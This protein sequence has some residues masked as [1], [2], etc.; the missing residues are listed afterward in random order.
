MHSGPIPWGT[1]SILPSRWGAGRG[2]DWES[3]H[4][5]VVRPLGTPQAL[6]PAR[7]KRLSGPSLFPSLTSSSPICG[8]A[9]PV[10]TLGCPNNNTSDGTPQQGQAVR[11]RGEHVLRLWLLQTAVPRRGGGPRS[12][13]KG[14]AA[15]GD[16]SM[17]VERRTSQ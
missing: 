15:S 4:P 17:T 13:V 8:V 5:S 6:R 11:R 14:A 12:Y 16:A 7:G 2:E 1:V 3:A 9:G 10:W